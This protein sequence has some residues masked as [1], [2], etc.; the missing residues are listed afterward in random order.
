[1]CGCNKTEGPQTPISGLLVAVRD[2]IGYQEEL[3]N[4]SMALKREAAI[5]AMSR[6]QKEILIRELR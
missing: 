1:M 6:R 3:P 5:K 4:Q 2:L